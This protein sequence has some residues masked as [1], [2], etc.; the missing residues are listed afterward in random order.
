MKTTLLAATLV[1]LLPVGVCVAGE[2]TVLPPLLVAMGAH[3]EHMPVNQGGDILAFDRPLCARS[4]L[5]GPVP[6]DDALQFVQGGDLQWAGPIAAP[7]Y[8]QEGSG[9][10]P[11]GS[12]GLFNQVLSQALLVLPSNETRP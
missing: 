10:C 1:I 7:V 11:T 6:A 3:V 9:R 2:S 4:F 8:Y 5:H 12:A